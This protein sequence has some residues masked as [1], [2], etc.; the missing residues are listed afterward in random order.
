MDGQTDII[1]DA[2]ELDA[3]L[4]LIHEALDG[5]IP[6]CFKGLMPDFVLK[7]G[8]PGHQLKGAGRSGVADARMRHSP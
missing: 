8:R 2:L 1:D 4:T 6:P 7:G 3:E 5:P